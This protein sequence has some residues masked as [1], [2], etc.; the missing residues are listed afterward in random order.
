MKNNHRRDEA[1]VRHFVEELVI[2]WH[3]T[4]HY[5]QSQKSDLYKTVTVENPIHASHI[6]NL[7][8]PCVN[9]PP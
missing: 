3:L 1:G 2:N 6:E 7:T 5:P 4:G 8:P 9:S